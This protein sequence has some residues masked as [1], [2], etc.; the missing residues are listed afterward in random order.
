MN[1][2]AVH[3]APVS[4]VMQQ[5]DAHARLLLLLYDPALGGETP[6]QLQRFPCC[7]QLICLCCC[8]GRK[9]SFFGRLPGRRLAQAGRLRKLNELRQ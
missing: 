6:S 5:P 3:A 8:A 7:Y 9:V 1:N 2:S 4:A